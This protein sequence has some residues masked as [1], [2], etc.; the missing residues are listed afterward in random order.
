MLSLDNQASE[1]FGEFV[2]G[3]W[4][5][6]ASS[7]WLMGTVPPPAAERQLEPLWGHSQR[8]LQADTACSFAG[9]PPAR[10]YVNLPVG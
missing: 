9:R 7:F 4:G 3:H 2:S 5:L 10:L 1:S 6:H 8:T